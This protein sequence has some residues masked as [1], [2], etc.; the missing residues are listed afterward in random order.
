MKTRLRGTRMKRAHMQRINSGKGH[1]VQGQVHLSMVRICRLLLR[2]HLPEHH[3]SGA[4]E[5][6]EGER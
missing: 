2:P 3:D 6:V 4:V 5:G 1:I